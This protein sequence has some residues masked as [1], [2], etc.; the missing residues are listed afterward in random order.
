MRKWLKVTE[1]F[2]EYREEFDFLR[3]ESWAK[4][5]LLNRE[6]GDHDKRIYT[7]GLFDTHVGSIV[8]RCHE[9]QVQKQIQQMIELN[10]HAHFKQIV[11]SQPEGFFVGNDRSVRLFFSFS[12]VPVTS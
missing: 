3:L 8:F 9:S 12:E 2:M 4:G 5:Y 1:E 11:V 7:V 6:P 10:S